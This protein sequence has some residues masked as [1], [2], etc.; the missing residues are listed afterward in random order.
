[1]GRLTCHADQTHVIL[2]EFAESNPFPALKQTTEITP[3]NDAG[4]STGAE[5]LRIVSGTVSDRFLAYDRTAKTAVE[6]KKKNAG[7]PGAAALR[8]SS[9]AIFDEVFTGVGLCTFWLT[10]RQYLSSPT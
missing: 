4:A 10:T 3:G 7:G 9:Q 8:L 6:R 1:M 2:A 5:G